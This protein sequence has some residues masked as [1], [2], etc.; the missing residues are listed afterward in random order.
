MNL[1]NVMS[2]IFLMIA[3]SLSCLNSFT[4]VEVHF[5]TPKNLLNGDKTLEKRLKDYL[6]GA[7]AHSRVY[8]NFYQFKSNKILQAIRDAHYRGVIFHIV[9]DNNA[10]KDTYKKS[11]DSLIEIIGAQNVMICKTPGCINPNRNNHNKFFLFEKVI[12]KE[13]I[14]EYI[15]IQTS[16]NFKISTLF[17]LF[18][19]LG[20]VEF[21]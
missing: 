8:I 9:M 5:N 7:Q 1:K 11:T 20:K 14:V 6:D 16:H 12:L 4:Q 19:I 10:L 3:L 13:T 17:K 2:Q 21:R 15:T 18:N